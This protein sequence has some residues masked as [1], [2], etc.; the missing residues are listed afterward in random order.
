MDFSITDEQR[1][2]LSR[3]D[4]FC[5]DNLSESDI[6]RWFEEGGVPDSFMS[7]YYREEFG[8]IGLPTRMGGTPASA[9]T[10]VLMLERLAV[11]AGATLPV[12]SL[13]LNTQIISDLADDRQIDIVRDIL[14]S[15]GKPGFSFAI[16]EPQSGSDSLNVHTTAIETDEG[17]VIS[18]AK[19]F[20]SSGQYAPFIVLI[21]HDV[22]LTEEA[23]EDRK[24]LTFFFLPRDSK[25][26]DTFSISKAGQH[27]IP[28]AE[29]LFDDV[30]VDKDAVMG[31]RGSGAK[32]LLR[33]FELG[34]TY[35]CATTV[36]MAQAAFNQAVS[37][38]LNRASS[39][40]SILSFQQIE[41][42][43][44]DMQIKIDAMRGMLY[45]TACNLDDQNKDTR[46]DTALLKRFVPR[47]AM[48]V[49]DNA[50]QIMGSMGYLSS[51]RAARI[52]KECRGNRIAEGTDEI[53]TVIAAKR[54][55]RRAE[56][57]QKEP[58]VWRF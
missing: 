20:V 30:F 11:H 16:T 54:I 53:M 57:E 55:T 34:R 5:E 26:V 44:T 56:A 22:A 36:G 38:A 18:G 33:I 37:F 2:L 47:T 50:M 1:N 46:L 35:V 51:T 49:A 31:E 21:A 8:T 4:K 10:R 29:M 9:V 43:I 19:S 28:T 6:Q 14:E 3:L 15:T 17:F 12:Q 48:E 52:W 40:I 27:L 7:N 58:P 25:G 42:M 41:E 32:A 45:K 24:P 23:A 13:M 39:G